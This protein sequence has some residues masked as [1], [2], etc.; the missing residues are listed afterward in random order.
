MILSTHAIVGAAFASFLPSHPVAAAAVGFASHFALDAIPHWDYPIRSESL[1]RRRNLGLFFD[2]ALLRDVAIIGCDG[3]AGLAAAVILFAT[4]I[5]FNVI[6]IG[7]LA[8]MLPDP[9]QFLYTRYPRGPLRSLQH[10]HIWIHTDLRLDDRMLIG[11]GSQ[12][13]FVAAV[14]SLTH[15]I[16]GRL[17]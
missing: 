7:A 3:L 9:L 1:Q 16:H 13:T 10:F 8:A 17:A 11:I 5:S 6:L 12:L 15:Y 2:W 14:V 4:P